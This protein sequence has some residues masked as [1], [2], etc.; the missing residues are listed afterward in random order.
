[1]EPG[2][3]R[4]NASKHETAF[5][6]EPQSGIP[7]SVKARFQVNIL[8]DQLNDVDLFKHVPRRTFFPVIWF[9]SKF[10]LAD[11]LA[12]QMWLL[13]HLTTMLYAGGLMMVNSHLNRY[14]LFLVNA[15][16]QIIKMK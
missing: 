14:Q 10:D 11:S 4:P 9:E 13:S 3:L 5:V 1:M 16:R 15:Q 2:T 7:I 6:I 12:G 8:V